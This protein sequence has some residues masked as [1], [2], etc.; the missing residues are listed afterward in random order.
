MNFILGE[1]GF[2]SRLMEEV[3]EKRGL[4][5]RHLDRTL[6]DGAVLGLGRQC[7]HR[8]RP[9]RRDHRHHQARD[10]PDGRGRPDREG[11]CEAKTYITGS[12]PLR[13]DSSR[14]IAS[15]LLSIQEQELG[16]DYVNK[17][18][19][20]VDAVGIDDVRRV[21]K[22]LLRVDELIITIVGRPKDVIA[23]PKS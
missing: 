12:Y 6:S 8:Q 14:K 5:Y 3:R 7:L 11:A 17:R 22:R 18:N 15:Q 2:G 16:I 13:F 23:V 4:S 21:A 10:R 9:G 20:L 19:A 1:G